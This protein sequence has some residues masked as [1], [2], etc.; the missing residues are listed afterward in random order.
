M[1]RRNTMAGAI[2]FA[3]LAAILATGSAVLA[4]PD[5]DRPLSEGLSV[6]GQPS[7][8]S[9]WQ[10]GKQLFWNLADTSD[11]WRFRMSADG[12]SRQ[13]IMPVMSA[14]SW[15][16]SNRWGDT[17]IDTTTAFQHND[18]AWVAYTYWEY[19]HDSLT[20]IN[21][22]GSYVAPLG[23]NTDYGWISP[24]MP[25]PSRDCPDNLVHCVWSDWAAERAARLCQATHMVGIAAADYVD[26]MPGYIA[27]QIDFNPRVVQAFA[28]STGTKIPGSTTSDKYTYIIDH[29][30]SRWIDF[31]DDAWA[32]FY[33]ETARKIE[34]YSGREPLIAAQCGWNV[35][36]RRWMGV[37]FR[38]YYKARPRSQNWYFSIEMQGD[39]MRALS[40][41]GSLIGIFG[42]YCAWEPSIPL[43]AKLNLVDENFTKSLTLAGI[44]LRDTAA[45]YNTQWFLVGYA[46]VAGRDGGLRRGAQAFQYGYGDQ[47]TYARPGV[48]EA[49]HAHIPRRAYGPAFFFSDT[50]LRAW[51]SKGKIWDIASDAD[52]AWNHCPH[53]YYVSDAALDSLK[54]SAVPTCWIVTQPSTL[55]P[56][57]RAKLEKYAPVLS[58][59]SAALVSPVH[60]SGKGKAWGFVDQDSSL[61]V[62]L[63]NMDTV[64]SNITVT[65][66]GLP[67][68][69]IP[70]YDGLADTMLAQLADSTSSTRK[71]TVK[72]AG[73]DTRPL[74]LKSAFQIVSSVVPKGSGA[75]VR[76]PTVQL[77]DSRRGAIYPRFDRGGTFAGWVDANGHPASSPTAR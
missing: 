44:P 56:A 27:T 53:G 71:F 16:G 23:S 63:T 61:V 67:K 73:R 54:P 47:P 31:W 34:L 9:N 76:R 8:A 4:K 43:G 49:I 41:A 36:Y 28:D 20:P 24:A 37:D 19:A 30:L 52:S 6:L 65:V 1:N 59:D 68:T 35:A 26:G 62:V 45:M 10:W 12:M 29:M 21:G 72:L 5:P 14:V 66:S 51:E 32:H 46:H 75:P 42:T 70:L 60:A 11:F 74:V 22:T 69:S 7:G 17:T 64:A 18:P 40:S 48:T 58:A 50:M 33:G 57:E 3:A 38:R 13:G 2:R 39:Y 77:R 55:T 25:L 15:A